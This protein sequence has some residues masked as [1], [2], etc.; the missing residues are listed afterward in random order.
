[1][2]A[3]PILIVSVLGIGGLIGFFGGHFLHNRSAHSLV[4]TREKDLVETH[5]GSFTNPLLACGDID[6]LSV[7]SMEFLRTSVEAIIEESTELR[8]VS[9]VSVY[10]RDLNN[11]PWMG[12]EEKKFFFPA[13]LLKVPLLIAAY[14]KEEEEPG[15]LDG[16]VRFERSLLE[17]T[18]LFPPK[19]VLVQGESYTKRDLLRRTIV[20]SDNQ[21]A[22]LL[23]E[24][25]GFDKIIAVFKDFGID[26]PKTGEDYRMRVRTYASFFRVLYNASYI[27]RSHSEESLSLLSTV[28]FTDALRAGVPDTIKVAH[29]FGE[30]EGEVENGDIQLHDCGIVYAQS[31]YL[32]CIMAQGKTTEGILATMIQI[33]KEVYR[34]IG[35]SKQ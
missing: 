22:A 9:H 35:D 7:G 28:A 8:G 16:V 20:H 27:S 26:E 6:N 23:G 18:Q 31:P 34:T 17:T 4:M 15:F 3:T 11:G 13:S 12:I 32:I 5:R 1:M 21:A 19:E 24:Q 25:I 33:S 29:K 14:K 10:V 30:R 2:R